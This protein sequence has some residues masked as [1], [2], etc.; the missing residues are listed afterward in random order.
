[1]KETGFAVGAFL[2][3]DLGALVTRSVV[4]DEHEVDERLFFGN[5]LQ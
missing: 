2:K 4:D 1:M 5:L 3:G